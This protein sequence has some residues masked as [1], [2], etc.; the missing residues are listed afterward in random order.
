MNS[1]MQGFVANASRDPQ[2]NRV[3]ST[4]TASNPSIYLDIDREKAQ[5]LGL[6]MSDVFGAL[7]AT[8]GGIYIN[9][10]NLFGRVWQV[11][12]QGEAADRRD[13]S[14]LWQ[15]YIRNK[16]RYRRAAPLDRRRPRRCR[17]ASD[18]PL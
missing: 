18:H 12:I 4:Y 13:V 7:Q 9:N 14:S 10:F 8:L 11:N 5:A 6:N 16:Y 1:V 3:F 15:I 17:A 2:L